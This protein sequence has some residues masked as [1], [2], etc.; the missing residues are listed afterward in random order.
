MGAWERGREQEA[1]RFSSLRVTVEGDVVVPVLQGLAIWAASALGVGTLVLLFAEARGWALA[2]LVAKGA[3]AAFVVGAAICV[4]VFVL[5]HRQR[6]VASLPRAERRAQETRTRTRWITRGGSLSSRRGEALSEMALEA[7]GAFPRCW[8]D[9]HCVPRSRD[10]GAVPIC[11][12]GVADGEGGA[13]ALPGSG[14]Y[15]LGVGADGGR[16]ARRG[17]VRVGARA[18][19]PGRRG[20]A[21]A[22]GLGAVR[23]VGG[24]GELE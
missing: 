14:V 20:A 9:L 22:F 4:I 13:R 8:R 2:A 16:P 12:D 23:D 5:Q 18:A 15:A 19:G 3:G 6:V 17:G 11:D 7:A 24:G 1:E 21:D 10:R